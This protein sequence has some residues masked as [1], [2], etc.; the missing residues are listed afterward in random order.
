MTAAIIAR[1]QGPWM[2]YF[3]ALRCNTGLDYSTC[4]TAIR[5]YSQSY[6][7]PPDAGRRPRMAKSST[8]ARRILLGTGTIVVCPTNLVQQWTA[9]I[10]KHVEEDSLRVLVM[11]DHRKLLPPAKDLLE[12]DVILFS[13]PRFDREGLDG[14]YNLDNGALYRCLDGGLSCRH[15]R[16]I[17]NPYRSPL[18]DI[19]WKRLIVDEVCHPHLES[20]L[21]HRC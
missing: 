2:Q 19:H 10:S 20:Y 3:N 12:Y 4:I 21:Y 11:E 14:K 8:E 16:A 1:D 7:V 17:R 9:E 13:R 6:I 5:K 18:R 15:C